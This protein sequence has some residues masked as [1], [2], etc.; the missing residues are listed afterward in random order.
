MRATP[1]MLSSSAELI[2][3]VSTPV[4]STLRDG[5]VRVGA[6]SFERGESS[7]CQNIRRLYI[8]HISIQF[9][10][11]KL[12]KITYGNEPNEWMSEKVMGDMRVLT[13]EG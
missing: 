12:M 4:D 2:G 5:K 3:R 8:Q 10:R 11:Q 9:A 6:N 13:A 1:E 7:P